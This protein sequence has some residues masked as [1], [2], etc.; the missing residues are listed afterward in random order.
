MML[1]SYPFDFTIENQLQTSNFA[2]SNK[3]YKNSLITA[4]FINDEGSLAVGPG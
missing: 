4:G 3:S 1:S 2:S